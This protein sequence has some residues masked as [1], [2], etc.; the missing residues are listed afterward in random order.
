MPSERGWSEPDHPCRRANLALACG[1]SIPQWGVCLGDYQSHQE[2]RA[3]TTAAAQGWTIASRA[4]HHLAQWPEWIRCC[5]TRPQLG[6]A[7]PRPR[8]PSRHRRP[9]GLGQPE[10][11][12]WRVVDIAKLVDIVEKADPYQ[13]EHVL[14]NRLGAGHQ[15]L[16]SDLFPTGA[17][18][19]WVAVTPDGKWAAVA[20]AAMG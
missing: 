18:P 17:N 8:W 4:G 3:D 13:R 11:T 19:R 2:Q 20:E 10:R 16:R 7:D 12:G 9:L 5:W 14:P 1:L 15:G 6:F